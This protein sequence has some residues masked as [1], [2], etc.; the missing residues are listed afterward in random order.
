MVTDRKH[1]RLYR[2]PAKHPAVVLIRAVNEDGHGVKQL[3][4]DVLNAIDS[5]IVIDGKWWVFEY[6]H[7]EQV[8][9]ADWDVTVKYKQLTKDHQ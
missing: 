1:F 9:K 7:C 3:R 4:D 8:S 6:L 5:S 2:K